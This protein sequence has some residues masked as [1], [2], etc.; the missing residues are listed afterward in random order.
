MR[1]MAGRSTL[2]YDGDCRFCTRWVERWR[3][4][5]GERVRYL[6]A[7]EAAAEFPEVAE[8]PS[9]DAVQWIGAEGDRWSGAPAVFAALATSSATGRTLL[10]LYQ[11]TPWFARTA[12][13]AY[14]LVARHRMFFS[15]FTRL[16]WGADVRPPTFAV[17][18]WIFLRLLGLIY[19]MAFLSYGM[20][21]SG[22]N[23]DHGILPASEFFRMARQVLGSEA[24]LRLP[25]VCWLGASEAALQA[26]CGVGIIASLVLLAGFLPLLC[27][28]VLWTTY[29]SLTVAGQTFYQFQWDILLLEAGFLAIFL[30][31]VGLRL[32]G[33]A[34]PPRAA[35]SGGLVALS[36]DFLFGCG[37]IDQRGSH[38]GERDRA[39]LSLFHAAS[40]DPA[41]VVCA[42]VALVVARAEWVGDV[43]HRAG[44]SLFA[45]R[46]QEPPAVSGGRHRRAA[47]RDRPD[48]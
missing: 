9:F 4:T 8:N 20:Q 7:Q 38:V 30:S 39:R 43:F 21:L 5:T 27:L 31:P 18:T 6:T 40:S 16:L 42:A 2:I 26:W 14:R 36:P 34:N 41:G 12:D 3:I 28:V 32:G 45:L 29:L 13:T 47:T 35:L 19:L 37:Q 24:F 25:S 48:R 22:L 1:K 15:Q 17:S 10:S 23:G 33:P 11:R 46:A 44:A